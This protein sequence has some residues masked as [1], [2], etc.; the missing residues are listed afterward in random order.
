MYVNLE[1]SMGFG[2]VIIIMGFD[3]DGAIDIVINK[4]TYRNV[5]GTAKTIM[6]LNGLKICPF[7]NV[8]AD[9]LEISI[10]HLYRLLAYYLGE[11]ILN[12][13]L[14]DVGERRIEIESEW[15]TEKSA[16]LRKQL[17]VI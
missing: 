7:I 15:Y 10:H 16:S 13:I 11:A 12:D 3:Y 4:Q 1:I 5:A 9:V 14:A 17:G 2:Q 6:I 8:V